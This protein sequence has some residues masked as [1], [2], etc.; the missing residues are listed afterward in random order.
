LE[1]LPRHF[2]D[3]EADP[4]HPLDA[5]LFEKV[6]PY[7]TSSEVVDLGVSQSLIEQLARLL[8]NLQ[9]DPTPAVKLLNRLV[10]PF[11]FDAIR[12]LQP[13]V[14]F[15][16]GLD[17]AAVPY[18]PLALSLLEKAALNQRHAEFI[19]SSPEI[20]RRLVRLWLRT[21]DIGV[22]DR[23]GNVLLAFL[24]ID[25]NPVSM[26]GTDG[27]DAEPSVDYGTGF[28]WKRVFGDKDVYG[29]MFAICGA[30]PGG[31]GE[32]DLSR[33]LITVAQSRLLA[34]LP[35]VGKLSWEAITHSHHPKIEE[36][37]GLQP[38]EGLLD[39]AALHV[40]ED[41]DILMKLCLIE[42]YIDLLKKCTQPLQLGQS[43]YQS[44]SLEYLKRR[45][46]HEKTLSYFIH[47]S[48]HESFEVSYLYGPAANYLSTWATT[49]PEDFEADNDTK[50]AVLQRITDVFRQMKPTQW[51][52]GEPPKH[53]L[54]VLASLPRT[55][56]LANS[57]PTWP[58]SPLSLLPT[59]TVTNPDVLHT[60]ATIFH[61]PT[62][63]SSDLIFPAPSP[64]TTATSTTSPF[65]Q[66]R[67]NEDRTAA[68][69]LTTLF[70]NQNPTFFSTI[71]SLAETLALKETAL[72]AI[73]FIAAIAT[74]NW[75]TP[76]SMRSTSA[77]PQ[78]G[79]H[80]LTAPGSPI[81]PY[82]LAPAPTFS[83]LVGGRGDAEN[84]AY[85]VAIA[86]FDVL[87]VV[88]G[89]LEKMR[90]EGWMGLD[91]GEREELEAVVGF[92][93]ERIGDGVW[94]RGG[95]VGGRIGVLEM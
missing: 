52:H 2:E 41:D 25:R 44:K 14:D 36:E 60:L 19:A 63:P 23:A 48:R 31:R 77:P 1:R 85:R 66:T 76:A 42:F 58:S 57:T 18:H 51:V 29:E 50:S 37:F 13:P 90:S 86:K 70:L 72:A 74:A 53:D 64:T 46:V 43:T 8:P 81:L 11:E 7:L 95:D 89:R 30:Q 75:P 20:I 65:S 71:V 3:V 40:A 87:R 15:A 88:A 33:Q 59:T 6:E 56:L 34:W 92:V 22:A 24:E 82:L 4:S 10:V 80:L 73:D 12:S 5:D 69:T 27:L 84:A 94:G 35:E 16:G 54:H 28:V 68:H 79:V 91:G 61:G 67:L 55:T 38:K 78:T 49:Y 93:R 45:G 62:D 83:N 26:T 32:Q 17:L 39:W 9:Q 47:P 21:Q